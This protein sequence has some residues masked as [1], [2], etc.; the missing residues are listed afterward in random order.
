MIDR[1]K[2]GSGG[3]VADEMGMGKT[4]MVLSFLETVRNPGPTLLVGPAGVLHQWNN[5]SLSLN[6][7]VLKYAAGNNQSFDDYQLVLCSY[8]A[9]IYDARKGR[10]V[11]DFLWRRVV[12]DEGHRIRGK[13]SVVFRIVNNVRCSLRWIL[14]GTPMQNRV[15]ELAQLV[16]F[17]KV[18]PH[19][20][21]DCDLCGRCRVYD[22][23]NDKQCGVCG[24]P[25]RLHSLNFNSQIL[26]K[27]LPNS[28]KFEDASRQLRELLDAVMIR[29]TKA[30]IGMKPPQEKV[31]LVQLSGTEAKFYDNV[32]SIIQASERS[33]T[34]AALNQLS[35]LRAL[36]SFASTAPDCCICQS[37]FVVHDK[38]LVSQKCLHAFHQACNR[39]GFK[40]CMFCSPS[41]CIHP[42]FPAA[43]LSSSKI[44]EI[45]RIILERP[46]RKTLLF[47]NFL[48]TIGI[49]SNRLSI[50]AVDHGVITGRTTLSERQLLQNSFNDGSVWILLSTLKIGE[51]LNLGSADLVVLADPWWNPQAEVQAI[52]RGHRLMRDRMLEVVRVVT[53]N[54]VEERVFALSKRKNVIFG[55][56]IDQT[57]MDALST[58]D[59]KYLLGL[60]K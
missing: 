52:H 44:N 27:L 9:L 35:E 6:L 47:S 22:R 54:T 24:C 26:S 13:T 15:S 31:C 57:N 56:I 39:P 18:E 5:Q 42:A 50:A 19:C 16:R 60:S 43:Y 11:N 21:Y 38:V 12:L 28:E 10:Q 36:C 8:E 53:A 25:R 17:L 32:E 58:A 7:K 3:I 29:R 55:A 2:T 45:M 23:G 34:A 30:S 4:L 37:R 48:T 41:H 33:S 59:V 14:T 49:I 40:T 1:E 20:L 46:S 51:G